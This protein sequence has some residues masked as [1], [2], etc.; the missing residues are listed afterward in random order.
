MFG[1]SDLAGRE[2]EKLQFYFLP[3]CNLKR[4]ELF[5]NLIVCPA[6]KYPARHTNLKQNYYHKRYK[7]GNNAKP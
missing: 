7:E 1:S 2:C 5:Y 6:E 3:L 4:D